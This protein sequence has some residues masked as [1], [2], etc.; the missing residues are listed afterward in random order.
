VTSHEKNKTLAQCM[1]V[2]PDAWTKLSR[3]LRYHYPGIK[4]AL[5]PEQHLDG[6]LHIHAIASNNV[7]Q[8]WLKDNARS[9]GLGFMNE[10]EPIANPKDAIPYVLKYLNKAI[11]HTDWPNRFRRVRTSI[12]WPKL[13]DQSDFDREIID[14]EYLTTY[15]SEGLDYLAAGIK[16]S[17]GFDTKVLR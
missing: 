6:R 2:W 8:R 10:S 16:E 3:R 12:R 13:E 5:L 14:W 7:R 1:Y 9:C 11:E 15:P 4:Y 17:T